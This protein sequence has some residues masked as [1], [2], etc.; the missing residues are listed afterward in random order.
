MARIGSIFYVLLKRT[1]STYLLGLIGQ[2]GKKYSMFRQKVVMSPLSI[3][4]PFSMEFI[5]EGF[6]WK[7]LRASQTIS[8]DR[9][10][11]KVHPIYG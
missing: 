8:G 5:A 1:T 4:K 2:S 10:R 11:H 9:A 6:C 7:A 3:K